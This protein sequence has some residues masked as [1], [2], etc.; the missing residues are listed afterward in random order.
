[1]IGTRAEL[2]LDH[3][4]VRNLVF[5]VLATAVMEIVLAYGEPVMAGGDGFWPR[6]SSLGA[7][8]ALGMLVYAACLRLFG[9][10]TFRVIRRAF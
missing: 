10:V 4:A 7:L 6:L 8:I 5:I 3:G 2:P 1:M 9:V